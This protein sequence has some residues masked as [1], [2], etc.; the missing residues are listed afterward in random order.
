MKRYL[1]ALVIFALPFLSYA[2]DLVITGS[3]P[4]SKKYTPQEVI[5]SIQKRFPDANSV[6]YYKTDSATLKKGWAVT[7]QDALGSGYDVEYYT[8]SFKQEGLQYYGLYDQ[9]GT[10]VEYKIQQKMDD[11]PEKVVTSLKALSKDH[12][13]Y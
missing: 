10:L 9:N 3:K 2:Q 13:G 12:P 11:L 7:Q 5:D 6:K 8:V 4:V 1:I